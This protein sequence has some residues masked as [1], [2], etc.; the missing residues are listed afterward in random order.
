MLANAVVDEAIH[1]GVQRDRAVVAP[2]E[3]ESERVAVGG[4]VAAA[5][6]RRALPADSRY[7]WLEWPE[8]ESGGRV[9]VGQIRGHHPSI[10]LHNIHY[11]KSTYGG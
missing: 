1:A 9:D 10:M 3:P 6:G 4:E 11:A 7:A 2:G 8:P 5:Y